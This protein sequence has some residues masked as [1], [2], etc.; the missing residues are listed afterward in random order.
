MKN[1]TIA[2]ALAAAL[3]VGACSGAQEAVQTSID[4]TVLGTLVGRPYATATAPGPD[5]P[6]APSREPPYGRQFSTTTLADGSRLYRHMI[7]DIGQRTSTNFLGLRSSES[8]QYSYRLMYFRVDPAGTIVEIANGF[9][10][11]ESERCVGYVGNIFQ[12]CENP[13]ALAADVAFFD[14]LVRTADGR[15]VTMAWLKTP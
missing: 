8:V 10:L 4:R 13:Q 15:P 14:S 3:V 6:F 9:W 1:A 11:G 12:T 7:R 2:M 5:L